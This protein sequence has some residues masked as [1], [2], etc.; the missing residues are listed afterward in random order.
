MSRLRAFSAELKR[1]RVYR[2][3]ALYAGAAFVVVEGADLFLPGLGLPD[4]SVT[5]V[6]ILAV[7]GFP[8]AVAV[9]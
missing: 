1:R 6:V 2:V 5:A 7:L 4:W 8:A 3:A 9:A